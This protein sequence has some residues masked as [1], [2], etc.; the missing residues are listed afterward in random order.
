MTS[1]DNYL[2]KNMLKVF[3]LPNK[4]STLPNTYQSKMNYIWYLVMYIW[5]ILYIHGIL[6]EQYL[7][8]PHS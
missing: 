7:G 8:T 3:I 1:A 6:S 4:V 5:K 2:V